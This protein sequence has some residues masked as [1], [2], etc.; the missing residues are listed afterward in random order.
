MLAPELVTA[1]YRNNDSVSHFALIKG[2]VQAVERG[3]SPL[4][5]WS[6]E[7][8]LGFPMARWYQPLSHLLVVGAYFGLAKSVSLL[9]L[10]LWA[11]YLSI[12]LLPVNFYLCA[13]WLEFAPLEAA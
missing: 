13:R 6:A 12:L 1:G 3:Q 8:S 10:F 5:F 7:T 11:K 4:D 2:M 9:T